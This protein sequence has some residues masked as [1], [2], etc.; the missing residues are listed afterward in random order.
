M[1]QFSAKT[2]IIFKKI[3]FIGIVCVYVCAVCLVHVCMHEY[4]CKRLMF[5]IFFDCSSRY[6]L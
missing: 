6:F 1:N 4:G 3:Y 5:G 2:V